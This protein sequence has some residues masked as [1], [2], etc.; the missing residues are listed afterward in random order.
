MSLFSPSASAQE[1]PQDAHLLEFKAG[2]MTM[3]GSTVTAVPD[4]GVVY[5]DKDMHGFFTLEWKNLKTNVKEEVCISGLTSI[6]A[7][8]TALPCKWMPDATPDMSSA[9]DSDSRRP[10]LQEMQVS[11]SQLACLL[12]SGEFVLDLLLRHSFSDP[13]SLKA[14]AA[15]S[16]GCKTQ[17]RAMTLRSA[18]MPT[19]L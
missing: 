1:A 11:S 7:D 10:R 3:E 13:P 2:R 4:P 12:H 19:E 18:G 8:Y 15:S 14:A 9:H 6:F 17:M 5:I 16:S